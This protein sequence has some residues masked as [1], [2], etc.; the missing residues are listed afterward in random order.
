MDINNNKS[1]VGKIALV[2]KKEADQTNIEYSYTQAPFRLQKPFYPEGK[3]MCHTVILH[4]AGG[5]VGGDV[6][7]Q[8]ISLEE[9]AEVF[10]TT[11]A[12]HKIYRSEQ[13]FAFNTINFNLKNNCYLEYL[14]QETIFF[15]QGYFCQNT[16]INLG[17]NCL[18]FGWEIVRFGRTAR[19]E[20]IDRG[21]WKN[22]TEIW[23]NQQLL[24]VDRQ[25][26]KGESHS[27]FSPNGL[28]A[29]PV[30]GSLV[31]VGREVEQDLLAEI[32]E[33]DFVR[34]AGDSLGLTKLEKGLLCRYHG[35]SVSK[36]KKH[37][38]RVWQFL[39]AKEGKSPFLK[40]RIW[41]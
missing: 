1:W 37:L 17:D 21:E 25:Y 9:G 14:P 7:E 23:Q 26:L 36:C 12:A 3:S 39:R 4:T 16:R 2:Y 10:I 33:L 11:P 8:N 18:Y 38:I 15:N 28:A 13:K 5:I 41:Q 34:Q 6:L 19:E 22:Y 29:K 35:D 20:I 31:M 27:F 40:S 30:V 32:R 24:W